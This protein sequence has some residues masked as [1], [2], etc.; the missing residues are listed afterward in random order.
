MTRQEKK[1]MISKF[2]ETLKSCYPLSH[3]YCVPLTSEYYVA[4]A[5][6][7]YEAV[8]RQAWLYNDGSIVIHYLESDYSDNTTYKTRLD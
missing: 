5:T 4:V 8:V 2:K 3:A 7:T 1:E 6:L